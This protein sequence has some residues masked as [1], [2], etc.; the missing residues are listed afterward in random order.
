MAEGFGGLE[1]GSGIGRGGSGSSR[2]IRWGRRRNLIGHVHH[3]VVQPGG[4]VRGEDWRVVE[5]G[6]GGRD[7]DRR[8]NG[9]G[10]IEGGDVVVLVNIH[11]HRW[12]RGDRRVRENGS[13]SFGVQL[14]SEPGT[15]DGKAKAFETGGAITGAVLVNMVED[16]GREGGVGV[17]REKV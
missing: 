1:V 13:G 3:V 7:V 6:W 16:A 17:E 4:V 14:Q 2:V 8:S 9:S 12:P 11:G 15:E 5:D 10:W